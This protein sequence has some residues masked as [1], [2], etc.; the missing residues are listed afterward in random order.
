[1]RLLYVSADPG[2]PILGHKGAS[3]HVRELVSA[4]AAAGAVVTVVSPRIDEEGD[5][6]D[7]PVELIRIEP[8]LP[9]SHATPSTL[10]VAVDR[11]A[12]RIREVAEA[13]GAEAVYERYSLFSDGGVKAA[14]AL[15][16][17]HALEVNALLREEAQRYRTLPHPELAALIERDVFAAT[18]RFFAVSETLG[19]LLE[20]IGVGRSRIEV[21]SNAVDPAKF[22]RPRPARDGR[23]TIGFAGSLKPW[24][25]VEVLL[26]AFAEALRE[27]PDLRLAIVGD[28]P[29]REAVDRTRLPPDRIAVHGPLS[30][31]ETIRTLSG[32]DVGVAPFLG[33][34]SFYFSPLKLVEY[35]AAGVCPVASDLPEIRSL[36][37][38]GERG[39]LVAPGDARALARALVQLAREPLQA[40]AIG[41]AARGY[42]LGSRTWSQNADRALRALR[43]RPA[44]LV[45]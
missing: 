23:F 27:I 2:V 33:M 28:G 13:V 5:T 40:A 15:G 17:P 16:L 10:R 34:P 37:G 38:D 41:A 24:H 35:M 44:E 30:H 25:G 11:Q 12:A 22:H 42:V 20:Q 4:F 21:A 3:V 14:G 26:D 45:A 7:V 8:V 36:L 32:W 31:S 9:R 39:V 43:E 19:R 1:M 6:L 18:G 29:A